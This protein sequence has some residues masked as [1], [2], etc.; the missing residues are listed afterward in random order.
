MESRYTLYHNQRRP[1]KTQQ[2]NPLVKKKAAA[3]FIR[4]PIVLDEYAPYSPQVHARNAP[5]FY[6]PGL[7]AISAAESLCPSAVGRRYHRWVPTA[8]A[9]ACLAPAAFA[10]PEVRHQAVVRQEPLVEDA[11]DAPAA[12]A[13]AAAAA[14]ASSECC[15]LGFRV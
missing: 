1:N 3:R 14:C 13:A 9:A 2:S 8:A 4:P 10:A 6:A 15:G 5:H 12:A 7:P 11:A